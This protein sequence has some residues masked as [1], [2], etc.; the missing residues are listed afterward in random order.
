VA[1]IFSEPG[2]QRAGVEDPRRDDLTDRPRL[3]GEPLAALEELEKTPTVL[4]SSTARTAG[5]R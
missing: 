1:G 5:I 4:A 3:L 2:W